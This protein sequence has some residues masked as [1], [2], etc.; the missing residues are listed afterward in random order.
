GLCWEHRAVNSATSIHAGDTRSAWYQHDLHTL[1]LSCR[2]RSITDLGDRAR[3]YIT[4]AGRSLRR[5]VWPKPGM[6]VRSWHPSPSCWDRRHSNVCFG[7]K[8][9]DYLTR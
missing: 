9:K 1:V 7:D 8:I 3:W 4:K 2:V 6:V 5:S